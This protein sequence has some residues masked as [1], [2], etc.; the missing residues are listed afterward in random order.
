MS[1]GLD[2]LMASAEYAV[3]D[4]RLLPVVMALP[5]SLAMVEV[6]VFDNDLGIEVLQEPANG[7][8]DGEVNAKTAMAEDLGESDILMADP[9]LV[10]AHREADKLERKESHDGDADHIEEFLLVVGVRRQKGIRVLG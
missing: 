6:V 3:P 2:A 1:S 4:T 7:G 8:R 9:P 5:P 10:E